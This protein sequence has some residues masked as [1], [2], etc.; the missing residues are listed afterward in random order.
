[1]NWLRSIINRIKK[2]LQ[3]RK[4]LRELAKKDPY[5]YR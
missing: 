5:L 1:M 4:K 2:D 3:Y